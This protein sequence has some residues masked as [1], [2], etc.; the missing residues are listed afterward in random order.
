[1]PNFSHPAI[2]CLCSTEHRNMPGMNLWKQTNE[3]ISTV[4]N[5]C[6]NLPG[7][8]LWKPTEK[9]VWIHFLSI[10]NVS[11]EPMSDM[12]PDLLV[13]HSVVMISIHFGLKFFPLSSGLS[14]P[15]FPPGHLILFSLRDNSKLKLATQLSPVQVPD[16]AT[17]YCELQCLHFRGHFVYG[18]SPAGA[19]GE[20]FR[21][22]YSS[23]EA[24]P[25]DMRPTSV[26]EG[27]F[28][29]VG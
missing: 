21:N 18:L 2:S 23:T 8:N 20:G 3:I 24:A 28:R 9:S 16:A 14:R 5:C 25:R 1:M 6:L 29:Y 15:Y 4:L 26:L 17:W 10:Q 19:K 22:H 27:G 12:H 7:M 11:D 13:E